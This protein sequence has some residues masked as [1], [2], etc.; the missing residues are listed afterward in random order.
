MGFSYKEFRKLTF[1]KPIV[2]LISSYNNEHLKIGTANHQV[3]RVGQIQTCQPGPIT[4]VS[5]IESNEYAS[6]EKNLHKEF[7]DYKVYGEWFTNESVIVERFL[8][9]NSK[10][11]SSF[12][13]HLP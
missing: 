12:Q 13:T 8:E 1:E 11:P 7:S 9:L 2:Y 6:I 4:I 5:Y 10:H 3:D